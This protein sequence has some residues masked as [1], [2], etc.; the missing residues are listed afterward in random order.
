MSVEA[1]GVGAR[2]ESAVEEPVAA[3]ST[4]QTIHGEAYEMHGLIRQCVERYCELACVKEESLGEVS[5]LALDGSCFP[6]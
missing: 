5:I 2:S 6:P 1:N 3:T 4:A